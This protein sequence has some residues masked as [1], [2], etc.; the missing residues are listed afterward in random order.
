MVQ[1]VMPEVC[2]VWEECLGLADQVDSLVL[3]QG[4]LAITMMARRLRKL[5]RRVSCLL[6]TSNFFLRFGVY[7]SR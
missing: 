7:Q 4:V 6:M 1:A 5:I 2:Q 3:A